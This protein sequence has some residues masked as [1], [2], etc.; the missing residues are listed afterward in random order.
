MPGEALAM[1]S[2]SEDLQP[3]TL[4]QL[5]SIVANPIGTERYLPA[6]CVQLVAGVIQHILASSITLPH[7]LLVMVLPKLLWPSSVREGRRARGHQRQAEIER[8]CVLALEGRWQEL[9][10]LSMSGSLLPTPGSAS[11]CRS[12]AEDAKILK[13]AAMPGNPS[14][15]WKLL[16]GAGLAECTTA[17]WLDTLRK[18]E[19]TARTGATECPSFEG[20]NGSH[21][22]S[23][24]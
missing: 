4:A 19:G 2:G 8:R 21:R 14:K 15:M 9:R 7:A 6:A 11:A 22:M 16:R 3:L 13:K 17:D 24:F 5:E 1:S 20:P 18:L 12:P 23:I 10:E